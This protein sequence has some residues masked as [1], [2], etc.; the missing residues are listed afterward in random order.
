M[1]NNEMK[2]VSNKLHKATYSCVI[3]AA[4]N[5]TVLMGNYIQRHRIINVFKVQILECSN[6]VLESSE[7]L[8]KPFTFPEALLQK[9]LE[10]LEIHK[11]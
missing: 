6:H 1:K 8:R 10:T 3:K 11:Y 5:Y 2:A 7:K 9:T 4:Q